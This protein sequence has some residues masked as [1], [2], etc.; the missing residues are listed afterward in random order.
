MDRKILTITALAFLLAASFFLDNTAATAISG[1][2]TP[3]L[4]AAVEIFTKY[5][6]WIY[7]A[8]LSA[9]AIL[10]AAAKKSVS[11]NI[12]TLIGGIAITFAAT[13]LL[14]FIIGNGR[15]HGISMKTFTGAEDY[16]FPSNHSSISAAAMFSSPAALRIPWIAFTISTMFSRI[17]LDVH[18]LSDTV[19]GLLLAAMVGFFVQSRMKAT[20]TAEDKTELRRQFLH[21]TI[22]LAITLFVWKYPSLWYALI[23]VAAAGIAASSV[24][25]AAAGAK[26][27]TL[28]TL[29][30]FAVAALSAFERKK[31]L[32]KFPGKGAIT[33]FLGAGITA[34]AFRQEAVA[35]IIILAVGDSV[36]H[37]AGR[38]LGKISHKGV[39][40]S[41]KM[42]E[43]T[44]C[45]IIFASAAA[46]M[47]V[48]VWTAVAASAAAMVIEAAKINVLGKKVDDNLTVPLVAAAVIWIIKI[49]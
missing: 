34:A 49:I 32:D 28:K 26:N 41:Q 40:E 22:G 25:K 9:T 4:T 19:G 37:I 12:A 24:I 7:L 44:L 3:G 14:K 33:L 46:A 6:F 38:L 18:F 30:K 23:L 35:A 2:H 17:Y 20:I 29:G 11:K 42:V 36:S 43:G 1:M 48:P 39:F 10:I 16:S 27:K 47:L 45:G 8:F 5:F 15:P 13:Y 21:L 31:E